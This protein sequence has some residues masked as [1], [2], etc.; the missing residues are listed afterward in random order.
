MRNLAWAQNWSI[1]ACITM[2]LR[3]PEVTNDRQVGPHLG[4]AL[5]L[6][7]DRWLR[8]TR[9]IR[10]P[11]AATVW[12]GVRPARTGLDVLRRSCCH[13]VVSA[14]E[15]AV[16]PRT[17]DAWATLP[18]ALPPHGTVLAW[19]LGCR[20]EQCGCTLF[21]SVR[22]LPSNGVLVGLEFAGADEGRRPA[23][24]PG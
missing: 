15:T 2:N 3:S 6:R 10:L 9:E 23:A 5:T 11:C 18:A 1:C 19:A 4:M 12:T 16:L 21:P 24:L 13:L 20:R 17:Y 7:H 22:T 8:L 14:E